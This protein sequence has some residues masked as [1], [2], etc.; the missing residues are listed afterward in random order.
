MNAKH[1]FPQCGM[2]NFHGE[3][4]GAVS[5]LHRDDKSNHLA[6]EWAVMAVNYV[7]SHWSCWI[8]LSPNLREF[9]TSGN[10][11]S[12]SIWLIGI[13]RQ[14]VFYNCHV[15]WDA[16]WIGMDLGWFGCVCCPAAWELL[17]AGSTCPCQNMHRDIIPC[18]SLLRQ[19]GVEKSCWLEKWM[20]S[21]AFHNA[22]WL[23]SM[24][25]IRQLFPSYTGMTKATIWQTEWAVMAVNYVQSHWSCWIVLSPNLRAVCK[26]LQR[27]LLGQLAMCVND[28][29]T[30]LRTGGPSKTKETRTSWTYC[31]ATVC[32]HLQRT[33]LG[34]LAMCLSDATTR[35]CE[36]WTCGSFNSASTWLIEIPA[37][38]N[39]LKN[40]N[41]QWNSAHMDS[42]W[43][44]FRSR[45]MCQFQNSLSL[46]FGSMDKIGGTRT[47]IA[48]GMAYP[49]MHPV[50]M[51]RLFKLVDGNLHWNCTKLIPYWS[52]RSTVVQFY[53]QDQRSS[54]QT[55]APSIPTVY[56]LYCTSCIKHILFLAN[57]RLS[58]H[59]DIFLILDLQ[60]FPLSDRH[61]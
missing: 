19:K 54:I 6:N 14:D 53:P 36:F 1:G 38:L 51:K 55:P 13:G 8:V 23:I 25:K 7:Q 50:H 5:I 29:T 32:K 20:L 46:F 24:V 30:R 60:T 15:K 10:F 22:V 12:A 16:Y 41:D 58:R 37:L 27:T 56:H 45:E 34:Q 21:M 35:L 47:S 61:P 3:N 57:G 39:S 18:N 40:K 17:R 33:L 31:L 44:S 49:K 52:Y 2:S 11:N 9:W 26:R 48:R 4:P 42:C 28:A 59:L 43:L